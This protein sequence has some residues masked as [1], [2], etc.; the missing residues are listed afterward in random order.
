MGSTSMWFTAVPTYGSMA[1]GWGIVARQLI[2]WWPGEKGVRE[3]RNWLSLVPF[4]LA[5]CFGILVILGVGGIVGLAA[6][7]VL[8]G[9]GWVGDG[10]LIWGVGGSRSAVGQGGQRM[11]L[12]N[13]GLTAVLFLLFVFLGLQAKS[14]RLRVPL[15]RGA[16]AGILTGTVAGVSAFMAVPVASAVNRIA[17][18]LP[19]V[20]A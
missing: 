8:W 17:D 20:G 16:L 11:A 14:E 3:W 18:F 9:V 6:N 19:G 13:G 12:T 7:S 5:Y 10:A 15:T 4:L 1:I 2:D